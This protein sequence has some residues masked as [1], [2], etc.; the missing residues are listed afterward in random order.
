MS[1]PGVH[2]IPV[3]LEYDR[4]IK[5]LFKDFTVQKAYLLIHDT[6]K[7]QRNFGEQQE[8]VSKFLKSIKQVPIEWEE[9]YLDIY[10]FNETFK[11]VYKLI[12]RESRAGNPV[13]INISS[14]VGQIKSKLNLKGCLCCPKRKRTRN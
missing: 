10:D 4:V 2:I 8:A 12:N 14:A 5:P 13:Y 6:K 7:G 11:T 9:I 1:K 3:G